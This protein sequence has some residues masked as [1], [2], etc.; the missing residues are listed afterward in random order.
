MLVFAN[1][2]STKNESESNVLS[3][4]VHF[5]NSEER[6]KLAVSERWSWLLSRRPKALRSI[7]IPS[8]IRMRNPMAKKTV[9]KVNLGI[10]WMWWL[11][12]KNLK[13]INI[14]AL[15][16]KPQNHHGGNSLPGDERPKAFYRC[17]CQ[18]LRHL[19]RNMELEEEKSI[20]VE[21]TILTESKTPKSVAVVTILAARS[22]TVRRASRTRVCAIAWG[23]ERVFRCDS[24]SL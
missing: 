12:A 1:L 4:N 14:F 11:T 2:P 9:M 23:K 24:I 8:C 3:T 16:G 6:M 20:F 19:E 7:T 15:N 17:V 13:Q 21:S 18:D 22:Q 10:I 5:S